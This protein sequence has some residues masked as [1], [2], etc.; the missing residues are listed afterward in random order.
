[1]LLDMSYMNITYLVRNYKN[2]AIY[3]CSYVNDQKGLIRDIKGIYP[4]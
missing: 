1:M 3:E 2:D 4:F